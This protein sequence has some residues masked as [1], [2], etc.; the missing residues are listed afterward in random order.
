VPEYRTPGVYIEEV[1]GGPRPV[2][3]SSTTNTGFVGVLTLPESFSPGRGM[4]NGMM[5]PGKEEGLLLS[6]NRALSFRPLVTPSDEAL[7]PEA[8]AKDK[9]GKAKPPAA[10]A[11]ASTGSRLR[12]LVNEVLPGS[13]T[14]QP[15]KD[16]DAITLASPTGALLRFPVDRTLMSITTLDSGERSWELSWGADESR[17]LA[18]LSAFALRS[19]VGH[20]GDLNC[21]D[22]KKKPAKIDPDEIHSRL[23]GPAPSITSMTGYTQWRGELGQSVFIEI[24]M[25][26]GAANEAQALAMWDSLPSAARV[27]WD[28]W[29]R[30]HPGLH[31]LEL[32][33]QG[34]FENGGATA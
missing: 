33:L 19:G 29:L 24:A 9:D 30:S 4:A 13:W 32:A 12:D 6:W 27:A 15:P 26:G 1:S 34:F 28:K 31:R 7:P 14:V 10:P 11:A 2:Q 22:G 21:V 23:L 16:E 20:S 8:A 25:Q 18:T 3:P 5:L 17:I